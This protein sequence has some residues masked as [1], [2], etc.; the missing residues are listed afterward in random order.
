MSLIQNY[1]HYVARAYL[2]LTYIDNYYFSALFYFLHFSITGIVLQR[3]I[4][5]QPNS[6][7]NDEGVADTTT[8]CLNKASKSRAYNLPSLRSVRP[9]RASRH[10]RREIAI[11][12]RLRRR[13]IRIALRLILTRHLRPTQ[14]CYQLRIRASA[15][16]MPWHDDVMV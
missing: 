14:E 7:G 3:G 10:L 15:G 2:S 11:S 13:E 9:R 1:T 5:C 8:Y 4:H 6:E 12:R 16:G